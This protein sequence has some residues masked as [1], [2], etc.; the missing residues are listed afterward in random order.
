MVRAIRRYGE[1]TGHKVGFKPAGGISRA[2]DALVY[3]S[4]HRLM[5]RPMHRI[6][7]NLVAFRER[8]EDA[9]RDLGPSARRDEIGVVQRELVEMQRG[10]RVALTQRAHLVALGSAVSKINHDLRNILSSAVLVTDRLSHADDPE[11]RKQARALMTAIDRA[12]ALCEATDEAASL[13]QAAKTQAAVNTEDLDYL[14]FAA[15]RLNFIGRSRQLWLQAC[16]QMSEALL[17]FPD[18]KPTAVALGQAQA[19][20]T[21]LVQTVTA[22]RAEYQRLWLLENRP[23]WL[24]KILARYD[25]L[26]KDLTAESGKLAAAQTALAVGICPAPRP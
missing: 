26:L 18:T 11:V 12:V 23:W 2:K 21:E 20:T 16:A 4:L 5:V 22:L 19:A 15:R 9:S 3:L 10:L 1:L 25:A 6:T 7:E 24:K 8:P 17:A 13:L 14:I